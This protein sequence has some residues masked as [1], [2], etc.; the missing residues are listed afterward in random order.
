MR[1]ENF[2]HLFQFCILHVWCLF[3][4][5]IHTWSFDLST[6][7]ISTANQDA[8]LCHSMSSSTVAHPSQALTISDSLPVID[9]IVS[10]WVL[11]NSHRE[12]ALHDV[13]L[14]NEW[15][16]VPSEGPVVSLI[17]NSL[18]HVKTADWLLKPGCVANCFG[19]HLFSFFPCL[20]LLS[21][22][23]PKQ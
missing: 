12:A 20:C 21:I 4:T 9:Y 17:N 22:L 3:L 16:M 11:P 19:T 5:C 13:M 6:A 7:H 18:S 10:A 14:R 1:D 15:I 2:A 8:C 23:E